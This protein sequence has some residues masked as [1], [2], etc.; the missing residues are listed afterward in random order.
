MH[1]WREGAGGDCGI[2]AVDFYKMWLLAPMVVAV[3]KVFCASSSNPEVANFIWRARAVVV[4]LVGAV[5]RGC[6][7]S[8]VNVLSTE[9]SQ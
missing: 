8:I 7:F 9:I 5:P 4:G 2:P 3:G 1:P 6:S